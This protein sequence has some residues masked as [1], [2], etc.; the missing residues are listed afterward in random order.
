MGKE[1]HNQVQ[2]FSLV[3]LKYFKNKCAHMVTMSSVIPLL[4]SMLEKS[5]SP[6]SL[7]LCPCKK[8]VY[9]MI[10]AHFLYHAIGTIPLYTAVLYHALQCTW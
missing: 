3:T 7:T 4:I 8:Q 1:G 9:F 10:G 6:Y 2:R 5:L